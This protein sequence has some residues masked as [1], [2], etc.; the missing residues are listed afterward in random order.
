MTTMKV[1]YPTERRIYHPELGA[2]PHCGAPTQLLN[3]LTRRALKSRGGSGRPGGD[4][5]PR[6]DPY[7]P[8]GSYPPR[9]YL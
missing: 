2:C 9:V 3:Y 4:L 7:P 5:I 6:R 1:L 8:T